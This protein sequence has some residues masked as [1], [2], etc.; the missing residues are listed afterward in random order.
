MM[1]MSTASSRK[2]SGFTLIELL[3]VIAII[4]ILA[5]ILFPVFAKVREKARQTQCLSNL[6][7]LGL[8]VTQ[9]VQDNDELFPCGDNWSNDHN[10]P[11]NPQ[12]DFQR[13]WKIQI[14]S[15][16][17]SE[18][19]FHCP[20]DSNWAGI[21]NGAGWGG[22]SY[23]SMFDSWY[24]THYFDPTFKY[25][26]DTAPTGNGTGDPN[27]HISLSHP[28][29][30]LAPGTANLMTG[31]LHGGNRVG[32]S[33]AAVNSVA[34][35]PM[36][37]D[38]MLWHVSDPNLCDLA[39]QGTAGKRNLVMVDGHAKFI[40]LHAGPGIGYAPLPPQGYAPNIGANS[41]NEG[42]GINEREW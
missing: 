15:Y 38:Q 26:P 21:Q 42:T 30:N 18:G 29:G 4:A 8:A 16:V 13:G 6:K 25:C 11:S 17:K 35:K 22:E 36:F 24:D 37:Y 12:P 33:I 41:T 14:T 2:T 40:P 7:Q 28:I 39:N 5:A 27:V 20:D 23:G 3:V 34:T 32:V 31:T 1:K 19:V 10:D 9:Y